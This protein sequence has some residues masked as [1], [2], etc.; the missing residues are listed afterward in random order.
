MNPGRELRAARNAPPP[1]AALISALRA[2][3]LAA[4]IAGP[5]VALQMMSD[6]GLA[7]H[8]VRLA[9]SGLIARVPK[10]SQMGLGPSEGLDYEVACFEQAADS[11]HVPRVRARLAPSPGLPR[12]ALLVEEVI[13]RAARLPGDLP[14][15]AAALA[16]IHSLPLP[17]PA[18]RVPLLDLG[19]P[20]AAL[21]AEIQAQAIHLDAAGL[22]PPAL[23]G[24]RRIQAQWHRVCARSERPARRLIAFDAHPGNFLIDRAGRAILV[25]LEKARY[26][27]PPLDLAHAT[28]YTSTTWDVA[29]S[30]TLCCADVQ[31]LYRTWEGACDLGRTQRAWFVP[32]RAA[33]WLWSITWCAQWRVLSPRAPRPHAASSDWSRQHSAPALVEHVRDRVDA[34]L[35]P[36]G[37]DFVIEELATLADAW[38]A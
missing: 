7:H 5:D 6:K 2:A 29:S 18:R 38:A 36:A 10:Q 19:D 35:S 17:A 24:I 22:E 1:T 16:A 23:G 32:L 31:T 4:R 27:H 15:I 26:S 11:G 14:A 30:A 12:G 28:L 33:M 3:L 9:G 8:H 13:G 21:A 20:L 34:Y 37:V 25:D